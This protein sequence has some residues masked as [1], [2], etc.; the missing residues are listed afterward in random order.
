MLNAEDDGGDALAR[1]LGVE[2]PV[3]WPPEHN[4]ADTRAWFRAMIERAPDKSDYGPRYIVGNGRLVGNCGFKGPPNDNGEVEIGYSVIPE[5]QRKGFASA[6]VD[7]LLAVAFGNVRVS[8]VKAET[9][10]TSVAS[11]KVL[12][13]NGFV[14]DG[15]RDDP[16]EGKVVC[17]RR[18]RVASIQGLA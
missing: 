1:L 9:L 11:Q 5:E 10:P 16:E 6:A 3:S 4:D 7:A 8:V 12:L 18:T 14:A 15:S 13:A 17:F 2:A